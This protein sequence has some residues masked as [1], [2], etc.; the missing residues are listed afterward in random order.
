[1]LFINGD[2]VDLGRDEAPRLWIPDCKTGVNDEPWVLSSSLQCG[3]QCKD[4]TEVFRGIVCCGDGTDGD[5]M[6]D[7]FQI[8]IFPSGAVLPVAR[9]SCC[10]GHQEIALT[11]PPCRIF[12]VASLSSNDLP[13][14]LSQM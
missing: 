3:D 9:R 11:L 10:Q 6:E 2:F 1:M 13:A 5:E 7:V 4:V 14:R 12:V 8:R